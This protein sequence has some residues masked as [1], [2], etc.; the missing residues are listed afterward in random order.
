[1]RRKEVNLSLHRINNIRIKKYTHGERSGMVAKTFMKLYDYTKATELNDV[2]YC[3]H[4]CEREDLAVQ[5]GSPY[6]GREHVFD[7]RFRTF[8]PIGGLK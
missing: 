5:V 2:L 4:M 6:H 1:M 3:Y 7:H 8:R